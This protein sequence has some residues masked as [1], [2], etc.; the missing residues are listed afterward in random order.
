MIKRIVKALVLFGM[1]VFMP[2]LE[3]KIPQHIKK[4]VIAAGVTSALGLACF[5]AMQR[6][7]DD[8]DQAL[9]SYNSLKTGRNKRLV[10]EARAA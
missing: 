2:P 9:K 10:S 1:L 3:S 7:K 8:L 6:A 5:I 4:P